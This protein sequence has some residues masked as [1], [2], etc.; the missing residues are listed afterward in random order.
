MPNMSQASNIPPPP[1][2]KKPRNLS[3]KLAIKAATQ[4][5]SASVRPVLNPQDEFPKI[6]SQ[7]GKQQEME[8]HLLELQGDIVNREELLAEKEKYL[9]A[10]TLEINEKE[11]LLEA[12]KKVVDSKMVNVSGAAAESNAT[13]LAALKALKAD[14]ENQEASLKEARNM[15]YEREIYIEQCENDLLD[16]SMHLTERE[17]WIEQRE[18]NLKMPKAALLA[19]F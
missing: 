4:R 8:A 13:E 16:K 6:K 3:L 14:L 11:A 18:E 15:L 10:R 12:H 7:S 17:A 9:E 5:K 19:K 1:I 2:R